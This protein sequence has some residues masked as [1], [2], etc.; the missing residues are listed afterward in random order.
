MDLLFHLGSYH[1]LLRSNLASL[2]SV[3]VMERKQYILHDVF[4]V[5]CIACT[6]QHL[7]NSFS[8][9]IQVCRFIFV[10]LKWVNLTL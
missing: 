10:K 2:V 7:G 9:F 5:A 8:L 1:C 6:H 4:I 3:I